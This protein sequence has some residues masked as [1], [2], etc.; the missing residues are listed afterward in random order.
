MLGS[1]ARFVRKLPTKAQ[2]RAY[3][4]APAVQPRRAAL[5]AEMLRQHQAKKPVA[6][7]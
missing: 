1:E 6:G 7:S 2:R 3:L 4:A 5:E